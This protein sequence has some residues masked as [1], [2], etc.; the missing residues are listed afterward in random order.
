MSGE[1]GQLVNGGEALFGVLTVLLSFSIQSLERNFAA[2]RAKNP[3]I[4]YQEKTF[5]NLKLQGILFST[6]LFN[7][8]VGKDFLRIAK[9]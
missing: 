6:I 8:I 7:S 9:S 3:F 1:E 5:K 4:K 2:Y